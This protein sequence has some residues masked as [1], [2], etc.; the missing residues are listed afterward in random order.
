[1]QIMRKTFCRVKMSFQG[2]SCLSVL[3]R[4]HKIAYLT[5]RQQRSLG[6]GPFSRCLAFVEEIFNHLLQCT[7]SIIEVVR[8]S[9]QKF[10]SDNAC[11]L[12]TARSFNGEENGANPPELGV[13]TVFPVLAG[14]P[15]HCVGESKLLSFAFKFLHQLW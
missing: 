6:N 10:G 2:N 12:I 3:F 7:R 4:Y 14:Q 8:S 9:M 1:M 11:S 15:H 5:F 13:T